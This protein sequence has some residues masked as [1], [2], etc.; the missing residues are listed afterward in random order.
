MTNTTIQVDA[1]TLAALKGA[2]KEIV[3]SA[4]ASYDEE[5]TRLLQY[6][7]EGHPLEASKQ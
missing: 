2:K 7:R 1:L 3:G 6:W 4:N 5:V